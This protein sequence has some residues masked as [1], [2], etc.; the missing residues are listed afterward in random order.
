MKLT[1]CPK[2]VH[3]LEVRNTSPCFVCGAWHSRDEL[4][5]I[6]KNKDFSTFGL[7][8][9]TEI[10]LCTHC[11]LED[12]LSDLGDLLLELKIRKEEASA[13][14]RYLND[15][16]ALITK[17]KYCVECKKRLSLLKVIVKHVE[18]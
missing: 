18:T 2:C 10:S 17:D 12:V 15:T 6:V 8:G 14:V 7:P 9:G 11:Y 4:E 1:Q 5:Q 16:K 3:D 13:C